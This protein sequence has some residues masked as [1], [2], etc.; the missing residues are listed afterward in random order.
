[1]Y[2]PHAPRGEQ[3]PL[4]TLPRRFQPPWSIDEPAQS[5]IVKDAA[6]EAPDDFTSTSAMNRKRQ[7][8]TNCLAK[9]EARCMAANFAKPRHLPSRK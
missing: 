9:D 1:M 4:H 6:G 3:H 5:F 8:A 7:S 2:I